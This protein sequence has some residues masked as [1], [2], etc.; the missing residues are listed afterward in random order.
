[1]RELL[2]LLDARDISVFDDFGAAFEPRAEAALED[3]DFED[4][5]LAI[6]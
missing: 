2:E 6:S 4:L 3:D 1:M 5:D